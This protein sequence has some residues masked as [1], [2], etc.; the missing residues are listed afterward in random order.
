[1]TVEQGFQKGFEPFFDPKDKK[2]AQQ[3]LGNLSI[4]HSM[5]GEVQVFLIHKIDHQHS[6]QRS[7][8]GIGILDGGCQILRIRVRGRGTSP[9]KR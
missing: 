5:S 4:P 2:D 7:G 1:M 3:D 6:K 8:E 9:H